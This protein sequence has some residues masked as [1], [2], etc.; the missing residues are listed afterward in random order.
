MIKPSDLIDFSKKQS[1]ASDEVARRCGIHAAYYALYHD[2]LE[3]AEQNGFCFNGGESKHKQVRDFFEGH[4]DRRA[5]AV[6]HIL[7]AAITKRILADYHLEKDVGQAELK[8]HQY[9]CQMGMQDLNSL[10]KA[11]DESNKTA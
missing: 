2:A 9:H 6:G 8:T 11:C 7:K 1:N 5:K 4:Q 3:W 10:K